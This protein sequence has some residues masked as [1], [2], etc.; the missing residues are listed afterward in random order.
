MNTINVFDKTGIE[1]TGKSRLALYVSAAACLPLIL[2][3]SLTQLVFFSGAVQRDDGIGYQTEYAYFNSPVDGD[4][5]ADQ[6]EVTG[7]VE[8]IPLGEVVYLVERVDSL[9]WPKLRIGS[10]PKDFQRMQQASSGKGYKY[11]IELLSVNTAAEAQIS[12]WFDKGNK[13]GNYPGIDTIEG[14]TVLAKVR[15]VHQ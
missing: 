4:L 14:A 11:T 7:R 12:R 15:V 5:V 13:T 10:E 1:T 3:G 8:S 2:A 9:F 6:F